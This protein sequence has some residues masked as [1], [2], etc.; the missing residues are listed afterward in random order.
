[1]SATSS[2]PRVCSEK[3]REKSRNAAR[4]RRSRESELFVELAQQLPLPENITS[5]LDKPS[6]MRL[7]ISYARLKGFITTDE[8]NTDIADNS[9]DRH[10]LDALEGFLM[11]VH[12]TGEMLF[13][14]DNVNKQLGIEQVDMIG[15]SLFEYIHPCDEEEIRELLHFKHGISS[16][17]ACSSCDFFTRMKC[18][19]VSRDRSPNLKP[20][21][22]K[23]LHCRGQSKP[24]S[25]MTGDPGGCL[26]L[27][28]EP[29]C[30]PCE[31][32]E[33]LVADT[34]LSR[35]TLDMKFTHCDERVKEL[36]GY[37]QSELQGRSV[38]DY[39]HALDGELI[40]KC[41]Q[42]LLSKGQMSTAQYRM[43]SKHGG[44]VWIQTDAT[45]IYSGRNFHANSIVCM[46]YILSEPVE[47]DVIFSLE[48]TEC[49]FKPWD[50]PSSKDNSHVD[51][52]D[53][54]FTKLRENPEELAQ[55]APTPGD[56]IIMLDFAMG[57][58]ETAESVQE[59][60]PYEAAL[61][62]RSSNTYG[63]PTERVSIKAVQPTYPMLQML[64]CS[65]NT[66]AADKLCYPQ[67]DG[68]FPMDYT[69]KLF[70]FPVELQNYSNS[71]REFKDSDLEMLAPYI[72]MEGED[73]QLT[74]ICEDDQSSGCTLHEFDMAD[75]DYLS[76]EKRSVP[77]Y[78]QLPLGKS[79]SPLGRNMEL[80]EELIYTKPEN[81]KNTPSCY[82]YQ[83]YL[84]P[85]T[86]WPDDPWPPDPPFGDTSG[87]M[88]FGNWPQIQENKSQGSIFFQPPVTERIEN[89]GESRL[90]EKVSSAQ[91]YSI[92]LKRKL[93]LELPEQSQ[94]F[95][96]LLEKKQI[97]IAP[98]STFKKSVQGFPRPSWE[99]PNAF[100][101]CEL[102]GWPNLNNLY[103]KPVP[104]LRHTLLGSLPCPLPVLNNLDC[105]VNAPL[106]GP[107]RLLQGHELLCVLDQV[108]TAMQTAMAPAS[109]RTLNIKQ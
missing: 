35:H 106:Q 84:H 3:R 101:V 26:V 98:V 85:F 10:I 92:S 99:P 55:L 49:F 39:C 19:W 47:T 12:Q 22:W 73:F 89:M 59:T 32:E 93:D 107:C 102:P 40:R 44:Y 42:N 77:G 60:P 25:N 15:Q 108:S 72:P 96:P 103:N 91:H 51:E 33:P 90:R 50:L 24:P 88:L 37:S 83:G 11:V 34:F 48:Q 80:N 46:N 62:S 29:I 70:A 18:S 86:S 94:A 68:E 43:L 97:A 82:T 4:H 76:H 52:S 36:L 61:S 100:K 67:E 30:F 74:P 7:A 87:R 16:K 53:S 9:Q 56:T 20:T 58:W 64:P 104:D 6:I 109:Q 78:S 31:P 17:K 5:H 28:C 65:P 1:M 75:F 38:Y 14:S 105:E 69:E 57:D 21:S 54:L 41:H 81:G 23:V 2:K 45:V 71:Q 95:E 63:A 66:K 13:L 79:L 8:K 27:L